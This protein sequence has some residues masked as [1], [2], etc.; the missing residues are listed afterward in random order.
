MLQTLYL[1]IFYLY[2]LYRVSGC[3]GMNLAIY[4][5]VG[6]FLSKTYIARDVNDTL[7]LICTI[8][9]DHSN[10]Y[11]PKLAWVLPNSNN[12]LHPRQ[13]KIDGSDLSIRLV[14]E[15]LQETDHGQYLCIDGNKKDSSINISLIIRRSLDCGKGVFCDNHCI[16]ERFKCDGV[17][18]CKNG[19]DEFV[20]FC[21]IDTCQNKIK[22]ENGRCIP[23]SWCCNSINEN[24]TKKW[25]IMC[26]PKIKGRMNYD[27]NTVAGPFHDADVF[28]KYGDPP[29]NY[30]NN[31]Q[32]YSDLNFLQTTVFAVFGCAILFMLIVTAL[33]VVMQCKLQMRRNLQSQ[34]INRQRIYGNNTY[35]RPLNQEME[36]MDMVVGRYNQGTGNS[37]HQQDQVRNAGRLRVTYSIS[38]GVEIVGKP[39]EPPPYSQIAALPPSLQGPPPPYLPTS[40][41]E[42]VTLLKGRSGRSERRGLS[43]VQ[44]TSEPTLTNLN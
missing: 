5:N 7:I 35:H 33:V 9:L 36:I 40:T 37:D 10:E 30:L 1:I 22:C 26:C 28:R 15:H 8:K 32:H 41:E 2:S 18:D 3:G 14:V 17:P 6:K 34:L 20:S 29:I 31:P 42:D 43:K 16:L 38:T 39:V 4:D 13:Y 21:G 27:F 24:C 23:Q 19:K 44:A 25:D 12:R 11:T